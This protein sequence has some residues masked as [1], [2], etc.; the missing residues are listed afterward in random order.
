MSRVRELLRRIEPHVSLLL[1]YLN[2][3]VGFTGASY[4]ADNWVLFGQENDTRY[5]YLDGDYKT[6]RFFWE[7]FGSSNFEVLTRILGERVTRSRYS[8]APLQVFA[9]PVSPV[10]IC[11]SRRIFEHWSPS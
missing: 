7:G 6:D 9:R 10:A 4:K 1:T 3:N 8:L 11:P 5:L 2:P